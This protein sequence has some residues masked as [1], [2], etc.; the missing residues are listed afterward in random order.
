MA[1]NA[2]PQVLMK[3]FSTLVFVIN[4]TRLAN[5]NVKTNTTTDD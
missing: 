3:T 1:E 5:S 2:Y 4:E